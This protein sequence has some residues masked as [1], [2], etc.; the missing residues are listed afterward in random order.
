MLVAST[1][2]VRRIVMNDRRFGTINVPRRWSGRRRLGALLVILLSAVFFGG[3]AALS[4]YVDALWFSSL[5]YGDVF[6]KMLNLQ[7]AVFAAA[8]AVT[9]AALY[10]AF[11]ALKPP[12]FG[13]IGTDSVIF[14]N[15]RPVKL[16]VG[17]V[18][19]LI[20]VLM[21]AVIA[22]GTAAGMMAE[23]PSLALWWYGR[24]AV[25][26][27]TAT[28]GHV[29]DPIFARPLA[30]YLFT[31]PV[32]QM[33]AGWLFRMA[34]LTFLM[35]LFFFVASRGSGALRRRRG[36]GDPGA[37][38]GLALAWALLLLAIAA[39]VYLGRF[40]RLF[41]DHTIFA[42]ITYTEAHVTLTGMLLVSIALAFGAV[43]A[44]VAAF[45]APRVR[46][47]A[48]AALPAAVLYLGT[49]AIGAYVEGFIVKPNELVR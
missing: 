16:P 1:W 44:G 27:A 18:L 41:G 46:W 20:A 5:G 38:R 8:G 4:Y 21:S 22:L 43:L 25:V 7:S 49:G 24:D 23:W 10:G 34:L 15:D 17:P 31:L 39:R 32:W 45:V 48:A 26:P 19:S 9:F 29:A 30:F 36:P 33:A 47:L 42:G 3:G 40:E 35:G 13:E 14:I 37:A 28:A 12:R 2:S 11:L 6:W